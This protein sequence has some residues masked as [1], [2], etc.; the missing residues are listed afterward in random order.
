MNQK[1]IQVAKKLCRDLRKRSTPS[2]QLF[3]E[4]V[5]N[6]KLLGRK[7]YRQYP[8]FFERDGKTAFVVA[9]FYCHKP[10]LVIEID[11][12]S[13]DYQK[14]YDE[15]RS[16]MINLVGINVLRFKNGEV[17]NNIQKVLNQLKEVILS[18]K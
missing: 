14:D 16:Y 18:A 11:G 6:N 2:E 5:R 7:F 10:K 4:A 1:V 12:K 17:E 9:D 15:M 13:H 8:L 3:W